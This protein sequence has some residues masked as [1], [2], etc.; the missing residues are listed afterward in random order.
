MSDNSSIE[1]AK[2]IQER[3]E[4]EMKK[5]RERMETW[6][7]K[8]KDSGENSEDVI[9][10]GKKDQWTLDDDNDDESTM[11]PMDEENASQQTNGGSTE[12]VE[13]EKED[14]KEI[15]DDDVD[16]LDAFM[17]GVQ[18][19]VK[20]INIATH[21]KSG[22]HMSTGEWYQL[23][24]CMCVHGVHLLKLI[25]SRVY[26]HNWSTSSCTNIGTSLDICI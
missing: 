15:T 6:R 2:K 4:E 22:T 7:Q 9:I 25:H 13:K 17:V 20:Q 10:D 23:Y 5:R 16:P 14:E 1:A 21:K 18:E 8:M 26:T 24:V 11:V 12:V 3:M 19:E